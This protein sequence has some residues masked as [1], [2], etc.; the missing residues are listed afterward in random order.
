MLRATALLLAALVNPYISALHAQPQP[1][2]P[3]GCVSSDKLA[4]GCYLR[5]KN[6][7]C[8][9]VGS[10]PVVHFFT[11]LEVND[12]LHFVLDSQATELPHKGHRGNSVKGDTPGRW[13]DEYSNKDL[14]VRIS[15][16]P[17][18]STCPRNKGEPCEYTDYSAEV[19]V[20]KA[21]STPRV[22]KATATCGC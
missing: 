19:T 15:Y 8:T 11:G 18:K 4:C 16:A 10:T 2:V 13:V 9:P 20:Q 1:A 7:A 6:L 14:R 5:V 12:P 21:G 3:L 22:Y 17:G